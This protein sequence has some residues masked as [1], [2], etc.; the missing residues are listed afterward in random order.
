MTIN[1]PGWFRVLLLTAVLM[2]TPLP[3][4]NSEMNFNVALANNAGGNGNNKGQGQS[5]AGSNGNSKGIGSTASA[6]VG[7][8]PGVASNRG[9]FNSLNASASAF[10]HARRT[11]AVGAMMQYS[12]ALSAFKTVDATDDPTAEELASILAKVANKDELTSETIDW[13]HQQLLDKEMITQTTLDEA[14]S[15]LAPA[16][17]PNADPN[18]AAT[19]P[20]TLSDL[21]AEQVGLIQESKSNKGLGP[22]Y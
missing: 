11:S 10:G 4:S 7:G 20:T 14:A 9:R 19:A 2:F 6:G 21:L 17:D 12:A 15:I 18:A 8:S 5:Q 13:I 1:V 3:F 22:I 16:T